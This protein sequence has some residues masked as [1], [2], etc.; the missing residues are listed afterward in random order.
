MDGADEP[1]IVAV[2]ADLPP[3][4]R[5][6]RVDDPTAGVVAIPP[7]PI[8]QLVAREDD[9]GL[10]REGQ[11]D[12]E[13]EG[14]S[15]ISS[16]STSTRRRFVS[17]TMAGALDRLVVHGPRDPVA[18]PQDRL[19]PHGQLA[20]AERLGQVVVGADGEPGDL[21]R[22][23]GPG[24]QHQHGRPSVALDLRADLQPVHP[25][26]I[27]SRTT[28]SGRCSACRRIASGPSD[29]TTTS[30]AL[31]LETGPDGFGDR[32]LVLDDEHGWSGHGAHRIDRPRRG[33]R[34]G[35]GEIVARRR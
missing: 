27:R 15:W 28:R 24:R 5:D 22:L 7:D 9:P 16:P 23:L 11:E 20:E 25:G 10:P 35:D 30:V 19:H 3:E 21:V 32:V 31:A 4:P 26:S 6:V 12:L 34:A 2:L 18:T 33:A 29:A 17:T 8:H 1:R 13:L 14:V